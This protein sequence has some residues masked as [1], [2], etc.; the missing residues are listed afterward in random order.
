MA[1][2]DGEPIVIGLRILDG[3]EGFNEIH[4]LEVLD[5]QIVRVRTYCFCPET[6]SVAAEKKLA[7]T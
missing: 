5:R 2:Y 6:L 4:R 1:G 7:A 3:I